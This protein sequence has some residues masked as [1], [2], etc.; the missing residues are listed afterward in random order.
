VWPAAPGV[1]A[2]RVGDQVHL[3]GIG[4][5]GMSGLARVLAARGLV[6]S[7]S[8]RSP[9]DTL[10]ALRE[11]GLTVFVGHDRAHVPPGCTLVVR[12]PAVPDGN[13]ELDAAR[14]AGIP[15]TKRAALMGALMDAGVGLAV[16]GTHGKTTTTGLLA[17]ILTLAGLDPTFFVG[18]DVLELGTNARAGIGPH[19]VVE[20]DE[21]DRTFHYGHPHIAIVTSLE[22][23]HPD[24]YSDLDEVVESFRVFASHVRP[25]GL[26]IVNAASAAVLSA[27]DGAQ[28]A[29]EGYAVDGDSAPAGTDL[30][31]RAHD[32]E[33]G[34]HRQVFEIEYRGA[35]L[36]TF[37]LLLP[38]RHSVGNALAAVAAAHS[39]G[40][41]LEVMR[42]ALATY[43]GAERRFQELGRAMG[44][45]VI[46]DYA[47]HPTEIA[48]T[49]Q[50]ARERFSHGRL[51]AIV[52]PHTYSRVEA[53]ASGFGPALAGAD[54]VIVTP[55]Y[56]ARETA[57]PGVSAGLIAAGVSG[58]E[59]AGGLEDAADRAAQGA[60]RGDILL[61]MGAG[62]ITLASRRCLFALRRRAVDE[63]E[64]LA[65]ARQLGGER[66]EDTALA[67][68]TSLR[69]GG[70]ADLVV[71][72]RSVDDLAGWH[73][74]AGELDVPRRILGRGSNVLVAD[75]GIQG[76]I[77]INRCE[78][79]AV[80][81][82]GDDT[83]I[84]HADSGVTLAALGSSLAQLGWA[85]VEAGIGIPGSVGAGVV[86]N[87]G[88]H[89]WSMSDCVESCDVLV[90]AGEERVWGHEELRFG[91]RESALSHR[92]DCVVLRAHLR[93]TRAAPTAIAERMARHTKQRRATQ[94]R[95]ASAGS[96]F[97]NPAGDYA[98]RLI[99]ACG[100]KGLTVG[101]ARISEVHANFFV[102][103][104]GATSSDVEALVGIA[105][106]RVREQFGVELE[107]EI[108]RLGADGVR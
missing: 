41:S 15:I 65:A 101:A 93:V 40:V 44:V 38:G 63:L 27:V 26:L 55:I 61:F 84:V 9:S 57:A 36:G 83:A 52:E 22:L 18:G 33:T 82:L 70:P 90:P 56:A 17:Y 72:V 94:P 42:E 30:V 98:G 4:G 58:A 77:L 13:P 73:R 20:A 96:M 37:E 102:N 69:V 47:H 76:L 81:P 48:A 89:G 7:G 75:R 74:L 86:T 97:K 39:L 21:Y 51:W 29:I 71:R 100:L 11:A 60:E 59:L 108:E 91:Y 43:R 23:D 16:A 66:A 104:G 8:D 24:V 31:W 34:G 88:A 64:Q 32:L 10:D 1:P 80:A 3:V 62:D 35:S 49:L 105:R 67:G 85:G 19:V 103:L 95:S 46:D 78:S 79:W 25:D 28:A 87:A 106:D 92:V 2:L 5:A 107:L 12:S 14:A 53:L 6:V 50:A 54:R 99:E 68:Y 45:R